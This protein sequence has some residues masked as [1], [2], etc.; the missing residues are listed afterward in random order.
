MKNPAWLL[1]R[2]SINQ[3][4]ENFLF[5]IG[6]IFALTGL[7]CALSRE[8]LS[9]SCRQAPR[10][11]PFPL[12]ESQ[13]HTH[14]LYHTGE[15]SLLDQ[16]RD[17]MMLSKPRENPCALQLGLMHAVCIVSCDHE[18][19]NAWVVKA[20][21][22]LHLYRIVTFT[23]TCA[24]RFEQRQAFIVGQSLS[25]CLINKTKPLFTNSLKCQK[26]TIAFFEYSHRAAPR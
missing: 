13:L 7:A 17:L 8:K 5:F 15:I 16:L 11:F 9:K 1:R 18:L 10:A 6:R 19:I 12:L 2:N 26:N 21:V 3:A 25:S 14:H 23:S 24:C 4:A 20:H 22:S